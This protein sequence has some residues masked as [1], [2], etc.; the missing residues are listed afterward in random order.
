MC[1]V[2]Y[3]CVYVCVSSMYGER[4]LLYVTHSHMY[5]CVCLRC[6]TCL[7]RAWCPSPV[8][9]LAICLLA[10]EYEHA[11]ELFARI[12]DLDITVE[13]FREVELLVEAIESPTFLHMR[14]Q[15]TSPKHNAYLIKAFYGLLMVLP[16]TKQYVSPTRS[17]CLSFPFL[18]LFLVFE[19]GDTLLSLSLS[20]SL[21][22]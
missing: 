9:V 12:A 6:M 2:L 17:F 3:V 20:F 22:L 11:C 8:S 19:E 18:S 14:M 21:A 10:E 4:A 13:M 5:V 15:L 1:C 16:Q 7:C